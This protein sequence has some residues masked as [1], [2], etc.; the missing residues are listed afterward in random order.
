MCEKKEEYSSFKQALAEYSLKQWG[1]Y[2]VP[3]D[4]DDKL[5]KREK[6]KINRFGCEKIG[7]KNALHPEVDNAFERIRSM[8]VRWWNEHKDK[9]SQ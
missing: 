3:K 7:L 5:S 1:K 6:R 4:F 8:L 9:V 2:E